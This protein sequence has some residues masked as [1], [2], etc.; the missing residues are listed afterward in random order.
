MTPDFSNDKRFGN[1]VLDASARFGKGKTDF[2]DFEKTFD[3]E[4]FKD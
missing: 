3:K 2:L 4:N 1:M